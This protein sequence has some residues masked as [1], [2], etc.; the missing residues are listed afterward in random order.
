MIRMNF[1]FKTRMAM[2]VAFSV[3][4]EIVCM[5]GGWRRPVLLSVRSNGLCF[6]FEGGTVVKVHLLE[7][8]EYAEEY[9]VTHVD[10]RYYAGKRSEGKISEIWEAEKLLE[11]KE[12]RWWWHPHVVDR[13]EIAGEIGVFLNKAAGEGYIEIDPTRCQEGHFTMVDSVKYRPYVEGDE[14]RAKDE[15][16]RTLDKLL[17]EYVVA[18]FENRAAGEA[19][20][21]DQP[22]GNWRGSKYGHFSCVAE[23]PY[24][25]EK[26]HAEAIQKAEEYV[27]QL[28]S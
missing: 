19:F 4:E 16:R 12:R 17:T 27:R 8:G 2:Q 21:E 10:V 6:H 15:A 7:V 28:E 11:L 20:I 22:S 25:D 5:D 18:V 23:Y 26:S 9:V 14:E 13:Y 24:S 3:A 1:S